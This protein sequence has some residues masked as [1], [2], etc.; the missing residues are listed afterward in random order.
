VEEA[1]EN[2]LRARKEIVEAELEGI[3]LRE[4][5]LDLNSATE[6]PLL[7]KA[8]ENFYRLTAQRE[9][10]R[11]VQNL[12]SERARFLSEEA[13]EA[14]SAGRDPEALDAEAQILREQQQG[15]ERELNAAKSQ[16]SLDTSALK[17]IEDKLSLE[18]SSVSASLRAIADQREGTARQEGHINGLKS[19]ID[20]TNA[21]V[22]RLTT[23][24]NEANS[25]LK[26]F[27][28][29]FAILETQIASVGA[30][31]PGLDS[32]FENAK[33]ELASAQKFF[34]QVKD[35]QDAAEKLRAGSLGRLSAFKEIIELVRGS[36]N[37]ELIAKIESLTTD[38]ESEASKLSADCDRIKFEI[39]SAQ[40]QIAQ[41]QSHYDQV[42]AK[43]N[44]SDARM[45]GLAEQM[46][47]AGQNVKSAQGEI[48]RLAS[49]ITEATSQRTSD[50]RD[51]AAAISQFESQ[52]EPREPDLTHLE[53]LRTK[54]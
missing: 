1:D 10:F 14:R 9:K 4:E 28:E 19:R 25:R 21:E 30:S 5:Q 18:E 8:Q 53:D 31:E 44:E 12:S 26:G 3:R 20:A 54:V 2:S 47:V 42:L 34:D 27:Q 37:A 6:N 35:R 7:V 49:S 52:S 33:N 11:G 16:L 29:D 24:L 41:N 39:T 32:Q 50:E 51:L 23:A 17:E 15:F 38:S 48:E 40:D 43:L 22:T 13:E 45:N 36:A 46:A